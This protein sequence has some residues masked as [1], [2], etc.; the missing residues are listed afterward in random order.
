MRRE[1]YDGVTKYLRR[2][3]QTRQEDEQ[4]FAWMR[5]YAEK[6]RIPI[7]DEDSVA[8]LLL[9]LQALKSERVL[10]IGTAI[11]YSALQ[12]AYARDG[13]K[14]TTIERDVEKAADA[15]TFIEQSRTKDAV[16]IVA[17]D[18]LAP[19]TLDE[20]TDKSP[21]DAVFIDAA[22]GKNHAFVEAFSPFVKPNGVIVIDNVLFRGWVTNPAIAPK[23]LQS[24]VK[25]IDT[26]NH[27]LVNHPSFETSIH[28]VGD[29]MAVAF[30]RE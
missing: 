8:F 29:G 4:F 2:L 25:K 6:N 23:R 7:L 21:F 18:A 28:S 9:I 20:L 30:K 16:S 27:W 3:Q 12:M 10:E 11:G 1:K 24:L 22:K 19:E 15:R 13:M 26:F 17:G 14:V 5:A